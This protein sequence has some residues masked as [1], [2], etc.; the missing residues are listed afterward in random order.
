MDGERREILRETKTEEESSPLGTS[1]ETVAE[2]AAFQF[3]L[4]AAISKPQT[5]EES[6]LIRSINSFSNIYGKYWQ[7]RLKPHSF[8]DKAE[9][10]VRFN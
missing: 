2:I 4:F 3:I 9:L 1:Q 5:T 10:L 6:P 7:W 8:S